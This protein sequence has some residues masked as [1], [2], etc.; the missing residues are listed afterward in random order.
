MIKIFYATDSSFVLISKVPI[1]KSPGFHIEDE[2]DEY[3]DFKVPDRTKEIFF[4]T[5]SQ[6]FVIKEDGKF[7][8]VLPEAKDWKIDENAVHKLKFDKWVEV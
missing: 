5:A 2:I 3:G 6:T 4:E 7:K 8:F 1:K